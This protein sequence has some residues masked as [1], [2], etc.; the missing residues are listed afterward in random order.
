M[1]AS[2]DNVLGEDIEIVRSPGTHEKLE[3]ESDDRLKAVDSEKTFPVRKGVACLIP[4]EADDR[5]EAPAGDG[6]TD[7]RDFYDSGGW[8]EDGELFQDTKF[9]VDTR[10][11]SL[12]HTQKCI[13]RL[14]KYFRK[15]GQYLLDAGGG[16]IPHEALRE[17]DRAFE[18]RVCVD[19]SVLGLQAAKKKLGDRGVC[20]QGDLTDLPLA[21][22]SMDAVT[23][24]H[25]IYQIPIELQA[26]AFKEVWR[27]L[28]PGGIG[29]VVYRWPY[30]PLEARLEKVT[31]FLTGYRSPQG[32]AES[33]SKTPSIRHEPQN[34]D[35]FRSQDWPFRYELDAF[36]VLS[37]EF[38]RAHVG[39]TWRGR[40]FLDAVW[41]FQ[42]MFPKF[43]GRH[44]A[45]PTILI[46]KD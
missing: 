44:G 23:C 28:K 30:S 11:A 27:V 18:K 24:N 20:L 34:L 40:L 3:P 42:N 4:E 25:V 43:C 6:K 21:D 13:R 15:G 8:A 14:N 9:F 26:Q 38:M 31:R 29:V 36:R 16:A 39:D 41:A 12:A 33:E 7:I 32:A 5:H 35:W 19:L 45:I 22:N 37:N 10:A 17:Y 2:T 46:Y 1:N